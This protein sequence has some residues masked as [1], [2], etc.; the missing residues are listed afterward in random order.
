MPAIQQQSLWHADT[1]SMLSDWVSC[2]VSI[3]GRELFP[4]RSVLLWVWK[5]NWSISKPLEVGQTYYGATYQTSEKSDW[6]L[7]M[8]M[9]GPEI[10]KV[11]IL[12]DGYFPARLS[13]GNHSSASPKAY[14][15]SV[16]I[17]RGWWSSYNDNGCSAL[18]LEWSRTKSLS[19]KQRRQRKVSRFVFFPWAS[20]L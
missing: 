7:Y 14:P 10:C 20:L 4:Y 18:C 15:D 2:M 5:Q 1:I 9:A 19:S 13:V 8:Q 11:F 12:V 6:D 17:G 16:L 3:R